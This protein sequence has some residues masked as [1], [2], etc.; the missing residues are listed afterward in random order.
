MTFAPDRVLE[1]RIEAEAAGSPRTYIGCGDPGREELVVLVRPHH[2][3]P[4]EGKR[5]HAV[6][7]C[8]RS[9]VPRQTKGTALLGWMLPPERPL[10]HS[11]RRMSEAAVVVVE[12]VG[13]WG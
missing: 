12:D 1:V 5:I 8:T 2:R 7:A 11:D 4:D 13:W 6:A 10:A 9:K 3:A